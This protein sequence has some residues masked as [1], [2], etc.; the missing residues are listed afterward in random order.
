MFIGNHSMSYFVLHWAVMGGG[1]QIVL[2]Y[3]F[4]VEQSA[5]FFASYA[6]SVAILCPAIEWCLKKVNMSWILGKTDY[7][8][9]A[10]INQS[11]KLAHG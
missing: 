10:P 3:V 8:T 4:H 6:V 11:N 5:V 2:R 9:S 1:T 7:Y